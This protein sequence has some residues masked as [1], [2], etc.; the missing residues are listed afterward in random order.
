MKQTEVS[1]SS[2]ESE[3][4]ALASTDVLADYVK[5]LSES[6]CLPTPTIELRCDNTAAIVLATG[7]GSWRTKSAANK[8][9]AVKEKVESGRLKISYVGTKDQ[10]ADA[11]TKF[12]RGGPDQLKAREQLSLVKLE[13]CKTGRGTHAKASGVENSFSPT[14]EFGPRICRVR[15]PD[16]DEL[17]SNLSGPEVFGPLSPVRRKKRLC[18]KS[19]ACY[20][21]QSVAI[22]ALI[23]QHFAWK[24]PH[25]DCVRTGTKDTIMVLI[26][27]RKDPDGDQ[28]MRDDDDPEWRAPEEQQEDDDWLMASYDDI[29]LR[30]RT[31]LKQ[32]NVHA[33][34]MVS[35]GTKEDS[36]PMKDVDDEK[37]LTLSDGKYCGQ[38]Y[39]TSTK[40]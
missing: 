24:T 39:R 12:L 9:Y 15:C 11:L 34:D 29:E 25:R 19:K 35:I 28:E 4:Q 10:C 32:K 7:E 27:A 5:T 38:L 37:I 16:P 20:F 8:V 31:N 23:Y 13:G 33:V 17:L 21:E 6:L 22:L 3:V 30:L 14:G 18:H 40:I 26:F 2:A 1:T 36:I